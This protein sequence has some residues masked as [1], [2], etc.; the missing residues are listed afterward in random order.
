M[1]FIPRLTTNIVRLG[2]LDER[3]CAVSIDSG[4]LRIRDEQQ[5]LLA[6]VKR[7]ANRLYTLR[8]RIARPLCLAVRCDATL[9]IWHERFGHLHFD[10]LR[11]LARQEMVIGLPHLDHVHQLCTD[12]VTTKLKRRPFPA[13]A[14]QRAD[15]PLYLVHGDLCG[16]SPRRR[17]GASQCS[18]CSSMTIAA[19]CG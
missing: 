4:I 18:C 3:G 2:Q 5:R 14:K 16:L 9:W 11:K 8:V 15:E 7:S 1:Y 19:S 10:A 17:S 6:R 13:V 12:C